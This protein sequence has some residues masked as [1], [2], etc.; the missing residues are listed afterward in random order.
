MDA[1]PR[2]VFPK[3]HRTHQHAFSQADGAYDGMAASRD[4]VF[5]EL[6]RQGKLQGSWELRLSYASD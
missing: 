1:S 2:L 4:A 3:G 6:V 5:P